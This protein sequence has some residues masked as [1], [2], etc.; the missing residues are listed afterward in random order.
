M[1]LQSEDC[2]ATVRWTKGR[3]TAEL[4]RTVEIAGAVKDEGGVW[5][6]SVSEV[7]AVNDSFAVASIG[8]RREFENR[9]VAIEA[10]RLRDSVK[11]ACLVDCDSAGRQVS[12][13]SAVVE[14]KAVENCLGPPA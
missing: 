7:E 13:W 1:S 12:I 6:R 3:I 11:I 9:A 5:Q 14:R 10:A 2:A 8:R 4:S